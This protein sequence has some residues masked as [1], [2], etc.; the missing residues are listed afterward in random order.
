MSIDRKLLEFQNV[1]SEVLGTSYLSLRN[2]CST[3]WS[4]TLHLVSCDHETWVHSKRGH[5][6]KL[7]KPMN[8]PWDWRLSGQKGLF[9]GVFHARGHMQ[10]FVLS[11]V[12]WNQYDDLVDSLGAFCAVKQTSY[13]RDSSTLCRNRR[14][15][16]RKF[17]KKWTF[18]I[19][20]RAS[21][22]SYQHAY[23]AQQRVLRDYCLL[24]NPRNKTWIPGTTRSYT[25]WAT[26]PLKG[27]SIS[28]HFS[29][30]V[31]LVCPYN[32]NKDS[33]HNICVPYNI[34]TT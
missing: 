34:C 29:A 27:T 6:Q 17:L 25:W 19:H 15:K 28:L 23:C 20:R 14:R 9:S 12:Y 13:Q 32:G 18:Y 24:S 30:A 22:C 2:P 16:F 21:R 8:R 7:S 1:K 31:A 5:T 4:D 33:N 10:I 26:S 3:Y 11:S